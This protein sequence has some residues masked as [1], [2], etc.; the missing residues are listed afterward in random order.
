MIMSSTRQFNSWAECKIYMYMLHADLCRR[1]A[2]YQSLRM[3]ARGVL[4][5]H[6]S[7]G[8]DTPYSGVS[9]LGWRVMSV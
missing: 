4:V 6:D 1:F 9:V 3:L 5:Q 8:D 2:C 7:L